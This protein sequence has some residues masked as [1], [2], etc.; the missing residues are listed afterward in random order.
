MALRLMP[1][2]KSSPL[3]TGVTNV[4][5]SPTEITN[6]VDLSIAFAVATGMYSN[7]NLPA[8]VRNAFFAK[9]SNSRAE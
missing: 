9:S 8:P 2:E 3:I 7:E 1:G 6:A 4:C 5:R